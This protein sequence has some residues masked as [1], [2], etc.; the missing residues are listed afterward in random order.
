M[1][2]LTFY[3]VAELQQTFTNLSAVI[4]LLLDRSENLLFVAALFCP[5]DT[6]CLLVPG[7]YWV[8]YTGKEIISY[9]CLSH[10]LLY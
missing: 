8:G 10:L 2:N 9:V 3:S 4:F 1:W 6:E 7:T 5:R